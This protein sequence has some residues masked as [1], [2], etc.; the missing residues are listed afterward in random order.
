M[1]WPSIGPLRKCTKKYLK[2]ILLANDIFDQ[3]DGSLSIM[4]WYGDEWNIASSGT[5]DATGHLHNTRG[6]E[7]ENWTFKVNQVRFP[8]LTN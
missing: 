8:K 2:L 4:Y 1:R 5:P 7:W 3:V 6:T